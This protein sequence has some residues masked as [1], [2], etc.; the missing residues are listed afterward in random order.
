MQGEKREMVRL[1]LVSPSIAAPRSKTGWLSQPR[2]HPAPALSSCRLGAVCIFFLF[3][4]S[5][6]CH[7][8][9][10][11]YTNINTLHPRHSHRSCRIGNALS[12]CHSLSPS[13]HQATRKLSAFLRRPQS[14]CARR[15]CPHHG[16]DHGG[17]LARPAPSQVSIAY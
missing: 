6:S 17:L 1:C 9:R 7:T 3:P 14:L 13:S 8:K 12:F 11:P 16:G 5:S 15:P 2:T 10:P 4:R